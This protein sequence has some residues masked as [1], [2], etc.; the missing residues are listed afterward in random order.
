MERRNFRPD[1]FRVFHPG[2]KLG[3]QM[4][5]VEQLMHKGDALPIVGAA[6]NMQDVLLT[7]TSK[8]FGITA[9]CNS[10]RLIGVV[11]DGD[12]RRHMNNLME[13]RA[14]EIA[15]KNPITVTKGQL[16]VEALNIM[17][18]RK[19]NAL[20]VIDHNFVVVGVLHIHDLLRAGIV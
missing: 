14:G 15:T 16:A 10:S 11:T 2:G 1:D 19:V 20:L 7:M 6:S 3:A 8:G 12:L 9:V 18:T 5:T 4:V 13:K 17:N